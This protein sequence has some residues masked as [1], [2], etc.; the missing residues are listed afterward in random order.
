MKEH[1][2]EYL[3]VGMNIKSYQ[4]G[5]FLFPNNLKYEVE[6]QY[7]PYCGKNLREDIRKL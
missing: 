6:I 1:K 5:S 2:C 4:W 7:C 3:P